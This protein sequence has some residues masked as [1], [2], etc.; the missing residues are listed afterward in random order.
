MKNEFIE[1]TWIMLGEIPKVKIR[2]NVSELEALATEVALIKA[3]G[4][5]DLRTGPL[6]NM[7]DG[8]DGWRN[9]SDASK[10]NIGIA[11]QNWW[12]E[13]NLESS[14]KKMSKS[15][16]SRWANMT[17]QERIDLGRKMSAGR[18]SE[19]WK[20]ILDRINA[21]Q[22]PIRKKQRLQELWNEK[23]PEERQ[24]IVKRMRNGQTPGQNRNAA[25]RMTAS[26]TPQQRHDKIVKGWKTRRLKTVRKILLQLVCLRIYNSGAGL[27]TQT[28]APQD[29]TIPHLHENEPDLSQPSD[30]SV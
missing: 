4:R 29:P 26:L 17:D 2:E 25:L 28:P 27:A 15:A 30:V 21:A 11:K 5:I 8:G 20:E 19:Q 12:K 22:D 1:Q 3:I 18:T 24:A 9:L 23:T 14:L 7:T 13:T 10:R 6:T 16:Q